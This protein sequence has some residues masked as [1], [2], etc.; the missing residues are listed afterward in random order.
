MKKIAVNFHL[1]ER[2]IIGE[3]GVSGKVSAIHVY[4]FGVEYQVRYFDHCELRIE[5]FQA[6]ELTLEGE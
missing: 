1:G 5:N 4:I 2:V 6:D 3:L